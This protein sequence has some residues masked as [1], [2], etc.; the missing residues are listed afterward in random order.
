[1]SRWNRLKGLLTRLLK[2]KPQPPPEPFSE[3][4]VPVRRG[5][6]DGSGAAIAE[7]DEEP[8]HR[9]RDDWR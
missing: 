6:K 1:M 5:P 4:L 8:R 2:R 7:L 9:W 3:R